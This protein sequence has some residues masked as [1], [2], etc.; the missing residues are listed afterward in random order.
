MVVKT[1]SSR[2]LTMLQAVDAGP[3]THFHHRLLSVELG[4]KHWQRTHRRCAT[5]VSMSAVRS[6]APAVDHVFRCTPGVPRVIRPAGAAG[7][8]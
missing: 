1:P 5:P 7:Q 2:R 4:C 8:A 6:R 3:G